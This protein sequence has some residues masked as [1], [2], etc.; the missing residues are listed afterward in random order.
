MVHHKNSK[1]RH[2][3][4]LKMKTA[5]TWYIETFSLLFKNNCITDF[6]SNDLTSIFYDCGGSL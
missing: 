2:P 4:N 3:G 1:W 6:I 5:D